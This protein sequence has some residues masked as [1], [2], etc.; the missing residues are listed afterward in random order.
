MRRFTSLGDSEDG[1]LATGVSPFLPLFIFSL[2]FHSLP[3]TMQV[4]LILDGSLSLVHF[5]CTPTQGS[6]WSSFKRIGS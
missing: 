2:P 1:G 6:T 3:G 5:P 4:S